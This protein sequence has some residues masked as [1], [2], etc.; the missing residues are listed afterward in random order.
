MPVKRFAAYF[1]CSLA[2]FFVSW[3][4]A[5]AHAEENPKRSPD[6]PGCGLPLILNAL[7]YSNQPDLKTRRLGDVVMIYEAEMYPDVPDRKLRSYPTAAGWANFDARVAAAPPGVPICIDL[8]LHSHPA[9][10][11]TKGKDWAGVVDLFRRIAIEAKSRSGGRPVGFYGM[12]PIDN[13]IPNAS[14][15][16]SLHPRAEMQAHNDMAAP[17]IAEV[18]I[19][20][21][22]NY[23]SGTGYDKHSV[24]VMES[25]AGEAV[26]IAPGKPCYLFFSPQQQNTSTLQFPD[27]SYEAALDYFSNVIRIFGPVGGGIIWGGYDIGK[28]PREDD[29]NIQLQWPGFSVPWMVALLE[30]IDHA[31]IKKPK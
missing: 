14:L 26:R 22:C 10:P 28:P 29:G 30:A 20:F 3:L 17:A 23:R 27:L 18:D 7:N 16:E 4:L 31:G 13:P 8:E 6:G 15:N 1:S 12:F 19:L 2:A 21:P 9:Y 5:A 11:W 24:R 25:I